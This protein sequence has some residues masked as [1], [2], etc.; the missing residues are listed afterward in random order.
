MLLWTPVFTEACVSERV[1]VVK[2]QTL[3][4]GFA[5]TVYRQGNKHTKG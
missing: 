5:V 2:L 1:Q 3:T 4:S